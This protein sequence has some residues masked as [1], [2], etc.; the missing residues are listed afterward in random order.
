MC[1]VIVVGS[2]AGGA[3]AA[4]QLVAAGRR[5]LMLDVGFTPGPRDIGGAFLDIRTGRSQADLLGE[6]FETLNNVVG[7]YQSPKLNAPRFRFVTDESERLAPVRSGPFTTTQSFARGGLANAWGAGAYRFTAEDLKAFPI[8]VG[9]LERY[10]DILTEQIGISGQLD[11]LSDHFGSGA[12]LQRPLKLDALGTRVLRAYEQRRASFH[13]AG[14]TIGRPRLAVLSD[15]L[16]GRAACTY[17]N[18]TFWEPTLDYLYTPG[19]TVDALMGKPGFAYESGWQVQRFSQDDTGVVVEARHIESHEHR[20]FRAPRLVL[21]AGALNSARIVLQ[22]FDDTTTELPILDNL[23]SMVPV[24]VP[25]LIGAGYDRTSHGLGQL[26]IVFRPAEGTGYL[27]ATLYSYTSLLASEVL[28]D[29]PLPVRG[30]L[31]AARHLLPALAV[32]TFFYPDSPRAENRVRLAVDGAMEISY[33]APPP[34]GDAERRFMRTML[35]S[36]FLTHP[37]LWRVSPRGA[38]IHY[39]GTLP[40]TER[41]DTVRYSTLPSGQLRVA[42]RVFIADA[43]VFPALPAKNHTFTIMANAMRVGDAVSASLSEAL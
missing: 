41:A 33:D 3:W 26:N 43:A 9:A 22:S 34:T 5:V 38:G 6:R 14:F 27:Q 25:G 20:S 16:R 13:S 18:L 21:A 19:R 36:G 15:A 8:P 31:A 23:P 32:V 37:A 4:H 28:L 42:P 17:D 39:A 10:Y 12:G 30:A 35:R 7:P 1:D 40:M 2:G 24:V 11:D 29:F